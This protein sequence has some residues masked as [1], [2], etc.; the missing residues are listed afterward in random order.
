MQATFGLCA[1]CFLV[2]PRGFPRCRPLYGV[3]GGGILNPNRRAG[4]ALF[5]GAS[6]SVPPAQSRPTG[7]VKGRRTTRRA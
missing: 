3:S 7:P 5:P 4:L 1:P 6:P 2:K